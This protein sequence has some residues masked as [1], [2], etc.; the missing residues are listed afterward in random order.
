M[1]KN[2]KSWK[3]FLQKRAPIYFLL[4]LLGF[5]AGVLFLFFQRGRHEPVSADRE[6]MPDTQACQSLQTIR[7]NDYQLIKPLVFFDI[8]VESDQLKSLKNEVNSYIER[9]KQEGVISSAAVYIRELN[10]E[11][12][13]SINKDELFSPGSLMKIPTMITILKQVE[14]DRTFLDKKIFFSKH[15]GGIPEQTLTARPMQEG[16]YYTVKELLYYMIVNSNNDATAL[17]NQNLDFSVMTK[18][19]SDFQLPIPGKM[20]NDYQIDVASCSRFLRVLYSASYL[21]KEYSQYAMELLTKSDFKKGLVKDI[22]PEL[23]VA[24]KFGERN[25]NGEQQLHEFGIFFINNN[26]YL[27]GVM[28]KGVNHLLLPD[29]L[30]GVSDLVYRSLGP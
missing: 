15:F 7:E 17:L 14:A 24:H 20:Q 3:Y 1:K 18:M 9:K 29:V 4:L 11:S 13:M 2:Q 28:T 23:A 25:V 27:L 30:S 22:N 21:S 10:N 12:W 19:F 8:N 6:I 16:V 26:P 5:F